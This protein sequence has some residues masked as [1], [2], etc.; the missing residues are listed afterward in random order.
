M[1]STS[2]HALA[3]RCVADAIASELLPLAA[4]V[5]PNIPEAAVLLGGGF[6]IETVDDMKEAARKLHALGPRAVLVKGGHMVAQQA[7]RR[8]ARQQRQQQQQQQQQQQE[9]GARGAAG[10]AA[11]EQQEEEL[12]AVDVLFDGTR[13]LE[14]R[15]PYVHTDNTHG[16]GCTLGAAAAAGLARGLPVAAAVRGAKAYLTAALA[17]SAHLALGAGPQHPFHHGAGFVR[18]DPAAAAVVG[19]SAAAERPGGAAL[20]GARW[21]LA[22]H[23]PN[24]CD[25]R[26]YV[27]TDP[28]CNARAGRTLEESVAAAVA[29]GATIVQIREKNA[30][31][32]GFLAAARAAL[33]ICRAAGVAL[34]I[35]DRVDIAI[36][37]GADGVHVGQDDLPA[38]EVRRL[39]GPG[40]LLGVSVKTP[41]EAVK[42]A[43]DGAD[44]VGCGAVLPTGTKDSSVI[45]IDGVARVCA[46]VDIP[47]V[48]IGGVGAANAA[49][50]VRAG[51]AG[52]A[53][54]SA[55]FAAQDAEAAARE[56]LVAVDAALVQHGAQQREG[57]GGGGGEA[58]VEGGQSA[59]PAV[60]ARGH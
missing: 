35:N 14:L 39:I 4:L 8:A 54:V 7:E 44:Y 11:G 16:T 58:A 56:L 46:A 2:G 40:K 53:V 12:L 45:G 57:G 51:A 42:A 52:I 6:S 19:P 24:P 21:L 38:R 29:G 15:A 31:G 23:R 33:K 36:A 47:V 27:V 9:A 1:I 5:T 48:A 59:S 25:L 20:A 3:G 17:G 43:A 41:E 30:D 13:F 37:A 26:V 50:I 22:R 10:A 55:V 34:I 18:E 32:G 49:D 28:G 60:A